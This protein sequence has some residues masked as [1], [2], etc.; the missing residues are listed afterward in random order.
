MNRNLK[1]IFFLSIVFAFVFS[2][3]SCSKDEVEIERPEKVY[4]DQAQRRIKVNNYFGAIESLQRIETQYPFGKFAEQAQID[5]VYCYFMNGETEAAHSSAERFIR[6]HPRH[7]NIDYAYFMKGMSSYTR[8]SGTL[9][10]VINTDLSTRDISGAKLA[11]SEFTEFLTR[12]PD[13]QYAPYA[14]K[15][16]V[17]IRNLVAKNE[18]AAADYYIKRKAYVAAIRRANYVIENIPNSSQNHRALQILKVS[19]QELGYD[20]LVASTDE[21]LR[22]NPAPPETDE[23]SSFFERIPLPNSLPV[24]IAG[25]ILSNAIN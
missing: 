21:L 18:L 19:Y 20:D 25:S 6:L 22:L 16:L 3:S 24:I 2:L 9:A 12:F 5:L 10:R 1:N 7:P 11:F 13:S 17:Y 4:Y 14:K 15:R 8:D 23:D